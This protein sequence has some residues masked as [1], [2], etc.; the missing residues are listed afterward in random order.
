MQQPK[1]S[2]RVTRRIAAV[3]VVALLGACGGGGGNAKP[4]VSLGA[5]SNS[6]GS[7]PSSASGGSGS[8]GGG[9]GSDAGTSANSLDV[10]AENA[11]PGTEAWKAGVDSGA[12]HGIEG[13]ADQ[14]AVAPGQSFKL[15]VNTVTPQYTATAFRI[16]YYG[17]ANGRQVWQSKPTAGKV[18]PAATVKA[19]VNTVSTSWQPSMTVPTTGW[20]EGDYL[21]KLESAGGG[22]GGTDGGGTGGAGTGGGAGDVKGARYVPITVKSTSGAG[23][24]ILV[25][26]VTTWQ[27]Y[28]MYGGYDLYQGPADVY[29]NRARI[30][31]FDRPYD[32]TG[33]DRFQT[34]EQSSVIFTEKLA[35]AQG[36]QLAYATDL[37]L[38]DNPGLFK[39]AKA[40]ITLGHDEYWS[41]QMRATATGARDSGT[42]IAFLGAN[43]VFRHIRFAKSALG[44]DRLEIC[45][46]DAGE[47]PIHD[48]DPS[49][50]TQDWRDAPD[51]RPENI[52][53]GVLYECNPANADLVVFDANAWLLAGTGA[54][55]GQ[56]FKNLIGVE[57]DR[58]VADPTTPHPIQALSH[59][60]I[61]CH[62][63]PSY[64]DSAYYTVPSGAGVFST[65]T[66]RWN[67]ALADGGCSNLL[68]PRAHA[69]AQHVT[70]TMLTAFA[71]GPAGHAHPA[72]DN[73][74]T[75][76][77]APSWGGLAP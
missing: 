73:M 21:I 8:S 17:G 43:A 69:F 18:Q 61:V 6:G 32:T 46:K 57:Y 56:H 12:D 53:T 4:A 23:K 22:G 75:L 5:S 66:M 47:D 25:N 24:V 9:S 38:H 77:P 63:R 76:K 20:P 34:Y 50:A 52:L 26:A 11:L 60:P 54:E 45:Y 10:K 13:Y 65:G 30:V 68:D 42:N 33:A 59:S 40:I 3:A 27:A 58:V 31:S 44:A 15:Y 2:G 29:A 64:S 28:N 62:G 35:A 41:T 36:L 14:V 19:G 7:A 37:D 48:T 71:A 72:V 55:N 74:A 39:G 49:E 1:R 70:A 51:P 16:G 67:C